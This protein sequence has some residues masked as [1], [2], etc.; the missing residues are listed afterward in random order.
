MQIGDQ[1]TNTATTNLTIT[2]TYLGGWGSDGDGHGHSKF[3]VWQFDIAAAGG[4]VNLTG[5]NLA[6]GIFASGEKVLMCSPCLDDVSKS[7]LPLVEGNLLYVYEVDTAAAVLAL[8]DADE[9]RFNAL[10]IRS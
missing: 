5:L 10:V 1:R 6:T 8:A 3:Q 7:V 9:I 4:A 2:A